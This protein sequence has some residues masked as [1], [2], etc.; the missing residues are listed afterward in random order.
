[1]RRATAS[2]LAAGAMVPGLLGRGRTRACHGT[3][4]T[5]CTAAAAAGGGGT[6]AG[7]EWNM[8]QPFAR[9]VV[10]RRDRDKNPRHIEHVTELQYRLRWVGAYHGPVSGYFDARSATR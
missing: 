6:Q 10:R 3:G 1:M 4:G 7:G 2:L 5:G 9:E 8:Q